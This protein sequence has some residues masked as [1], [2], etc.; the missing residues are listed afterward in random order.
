M[1]APVVSESQSSTVQPAAFR[2]IIETAFLTASDL[3]CSFIHC[4]QLRTPQVR[5]YSVPSSKVWNQSPEKAVSSWEPVSLGSVALSCSYIYVLILASF[6]G[7]IFLSWFDR[8]RESSGATI[9]GASSRRRQSGRRLTRA[10]PPQ[11]PAAQ[12]HN[13]VVSFC[14]VLDNFNFQIYFEDSVAKSSQ[15]LSCLGFVLSRARARQ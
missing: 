14:L 5:A 15:P 8:W 9:T 2:H 3:R 4:W 11:V 12:P 1:K 6:V 7:L 10:T 13:P